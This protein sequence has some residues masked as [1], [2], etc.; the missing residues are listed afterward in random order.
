MS[1]DKPR[2]FWII[3]ESPFST[4]VSS[5]PLNSADTKEEIHVIE[6]KAYDQVCAER[7]EL[8]YVPGHLRCAKCN[9]YL[10]SKTLYMKSGTIGANKKPDDCANGCGPM[11]RVTWK[12]HAKLLSDAQDHWVLENKKLREALAWYGDE[13]NWTIPAGS[14]DAA[15]YIS[16]TC[17]MQDDGGRRAREALKGEK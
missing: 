10:I 16:A 7:D 4:W 2:E 13:K 8:K 1:N 3:D 14:G 5:K 17:P 12:D 9:F 15:A 11:W 6:R